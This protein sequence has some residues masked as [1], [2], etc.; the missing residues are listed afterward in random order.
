MLENIT[1]GGLLGI[2]DPL[3]INALDFL[4]IMFFSGAAAVIT[5][6]ILRSW[7]LG[8]VV[9]CIFFVPLFNWIF[10]QESRWVSIPIAV[11]LVMMLVTALATK[12]IV[13]GTSRRRIRRR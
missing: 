6:G 10:V 1:L 7:F 5:R 8:S 11:L 12:P 2:T 9:F 13:F 4:M 3:I